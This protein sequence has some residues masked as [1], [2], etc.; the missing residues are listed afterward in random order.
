MAWGVA[1]EDD[2]I[3]AFEAHFGVIVDSAGDD[4]LW[5][6]WEDWAG[7][8]T[9]GLI[10]VC[11][12]DPGKPVSRHLITENALVEAKCPRVVWEVPPENYWCQ[13]Q[14]Q[15]KFTN[16]ALG[17][18][19]AWTPT[20]VGIWKTTR[21]EK[22]WETVESALKDYLAMLKSPTPPK[23]WKVPKLDLNISWERVK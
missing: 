20:E 11:E 10:D 12:T 7:C 18:L 13:V 22:Y 2:A 4:Q 16:R 19:C 17:Y 3:S 23:R 15:L 5:T 14:S 1:H 8:T 6:P 21:D 9:D